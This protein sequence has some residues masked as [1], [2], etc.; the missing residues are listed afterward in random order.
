M[1][2]AGQRPYK[3]VARAQA[4]KRTHEA[5]LNAAIEEFY[6]GRWPKASLEALSRSAGVTK[7]TLLR[8]FGSKDGLLL[9]ALMRSVSQVFD[10]RWSAPAGDIEGTI[11]NLLD[12]YE[13]WG[14]RALRIGAWQG[15][16]PL[17]AR[18]SQVARQVHYDWVEHAFRPWLEPLDEESRA[19]RY[20]AFIAI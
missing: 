4:Q 1:T 9:Q 16:A 3:Q 6:E 10:Q 19:R 7:Q 2:D 13:V 5:L 8:H 17:L 12:H 15:W 11:D 20:A 14:A 18:F